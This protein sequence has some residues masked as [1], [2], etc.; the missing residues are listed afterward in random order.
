VLVGAAI[1]LASADGLRHKKHTAERHVHA[2]NRDLDESSSQLRAAT[3]AL[4]RAQ[5][6]LDDARSHLSQT[7]G[8]LAAA[9]VLD[10]QM[11]AKLDAAVQRLQQAR[12][13][14]AEGRRQIAEQRNT[15]GEIAAQNYQDGDPGLMGLSMVMNSQDP[16]E[17]TGQLNSVQNVMDKQGT[18]LA[19]LQ[20]SKVLLTVQEKQVRAAKIEVAAERR[21]AARNLDRKRVLEQQAE[22]AKERVVQ[23]VSDRRGAQQAASRARAHD[24][25]VLRQAQRQEDRI[26]A[27]LK[28][29]A[30][31]AAR[32]A[33]GY[34]GSLSSGGFLDWPARGPVTSPF[35]WRINPVTH[36]HSLHDGIDIGIPC[37]TP[38]R[39]PSGGRVIA[40]YYNVAWGNRIIIGLGYHHGASLAIILNHLSGYVAH[41]GQSVGR[42]QLVAYSGTTGWSTGCHTHFTVMAN[43]RAVNPMS[44]L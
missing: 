23:L 15:L 20:A 26:V 21:Q 34:T 33:G 38:L 39:A 37:G 11:Q 6:R 24:A 22:T 32:R 8:Q 30:A 1:P 9:V 25:A 16:S 10:R 12:A 27:M 2:A 5:V 40:E 43:G 17:L 28:R 13:N 41:T 44:W 7:R 35:G 31:R 18:V 4:R 14:V 36:M 29:R 3:A 19:K 42:G